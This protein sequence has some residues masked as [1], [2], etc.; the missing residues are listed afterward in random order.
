M[1][2][3]ARHPETMSP[4]QNAAY[5]AI[6]QG[7]R[8]SVPHPFLAML[9]TPNLAL[10]IQAVGSGIR[11]GGAASAAIREIAIL[12]T[13]AAFGS[14]YEWDYHAPIARDCG[15]SEAVILATTTGQT[16][17]LDDEVSGLV[18]NLCRGAITQRRIDQDV[19]DRLVQHLGRTPASELVAICG[20]YQ[21]LALFLS[22]GAL[23]HA[24]A[25]APSQPSS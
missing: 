18:I 7:P 12:A 1:L 21:M 11:F 25:Y 4:E 17:S 9:D 14:G 10:A 5:Q 16:M 8:G 15:V 6:A 13:A 3:G 23:D 2:I 22:A 19:L 24:A 20:Y